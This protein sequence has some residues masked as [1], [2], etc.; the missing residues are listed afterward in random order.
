M[1]VHYGA[2]MFYIIRITLS[3]LLVSS[4][5]QTDLSCKRNENVGLLDTFWS[6]VAIA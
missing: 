6:F 3:L 1:L 5:I 4:K 2:K